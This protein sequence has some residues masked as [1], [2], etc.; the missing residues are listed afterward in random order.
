MGSFGRWLWC[1][2]VCVSAAGFAGGPKPSLIPVP[3][4]FKQTPPGFS[5]EDRETVQREYIRLLRL[6]GALIP[7]F[8]RYELALKDLDRDACEKDDQCL[9][10]FARKGESLYSLYASV[11]YSA[12]GDMVV[13]GRVVRDDGVPASAQEKVNVTKGADSYKDMAKNALI[14]LFTQL[15]IGDLSATREEAPVVKAEPAPAEAPLPMPM[16]TVQDTGRER[17]SVGKGV[18]IAGAAAAAA[19]GVLAGVG[20]GVGFGQEVNQRNVTP[21]QLEDLVTAR[22]LTTIG[23]IGIGAGALTAAIGAILWGT[24]PA[25][26]AQVSVLPVH[27]GGGVVVVGGHF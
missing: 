24:A 18:V 22:T 12:E 7:D 1:I 25:A 11:D 10:Q 13:S 4:T 3:L 15:K 9:A 17:R 19:G 20:A 23:F 16:V 2:T 27:G 5:K 14:N 26:P 6:A 21:A 8:G